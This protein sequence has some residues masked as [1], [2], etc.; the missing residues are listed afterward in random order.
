M[1]NLTDP[2]S[3]CDSLDSI[4]DKFAKMMFSSSTAVIDSPNFLEVYSTNLLLPRELDDLIA[5]SIVHWYI[6]DERMRLYLRLE[7]ERIS[8]FTENWVIILLLNS[9]VE[10]K[11][12]LLN[13]DLWSSRS[14]F[15]NLMTQ[16][17]MTK[18]SKIVR[19]KRRGRVPKKPQRKRGYD[20]KGSK[21]EDH[22]WKASSDW[23]LTELQNTIEQER[24]SR[25]HSAAFARGM[26][27]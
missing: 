27:E 5:L 12:F 23:S 9:K 13:S 26:L 1:R 10:M 6:K 16:K 25:V 18:I 11:L 19:F 15:G 14:F 17:R 8:Y 2:T 21:R 20:D 22:Q 4:G 24:E 7:L 3:F